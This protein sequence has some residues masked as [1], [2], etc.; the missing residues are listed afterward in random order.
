MKTR[1][2]VCVMCD[3]TFD[4]ES[5]GSPREYC[6]ACIKKHKREYNTEYRRKRYQ[7]DAEFRERTNANNQKSV[8]IRMEDP[9]YRKRKNA[10]AHAT[11][12]KLLEDPENRARYNAKKR[13]Q[14][15][16][17]MKD[18]KYRARA[19]VYVRKWN[20]KNP[21]KVKAS[22]RKQY[23]KK[24]KDPAVRAA[25]NKYYRERARERYVNDPIY[26]EKIRAGNRKRYLK[27]KEAKG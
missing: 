9:K 12:T 10:V 18:P 20:A 13:E 23:V 16:E 21:D 27:A 1:T 5:R 24:M 7:T 14:N 4:D 11:R 3:K 26:A 15:R 25:Y 6:D 19:N 17:R 8:A 22:R 2:F